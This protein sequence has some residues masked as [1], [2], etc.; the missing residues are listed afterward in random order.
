MNILPKDTYLGK[1]RF[2]EIYDEFYGPKCFSVKD[3][4]GHLYLVYWSGDYDDGK[5]TK[6]VYAPVSPAILDALLREEIS[7]HSVFSASKRLKIISTYDETVGKTTL[8]EDFNEGNSTSVNIPPVD[9]SID[10]EELKSIAPEANWDFNLRIAK[11][12]GN[13]LPSDDAVSKVLTA[14][15]DI[16]KLLMKGDKNWAPSVFPLTAQYGSFDVKLGS[17]NQERAA[18]A[19]E[20]L[21]TIL[22]KQDDILDTLA[23]LE[24][25]PYRM[26]DL[27]DIVNLESLELTLKS[28]TSETLKKPIKI[29]SSGLL[30]IIQKLE[31]DSKTFIDSSR[32]PQANCLDRVIKIVEHR[33][34]GGELNHKLIDGI[35]SE[36]QVIYHTH[37][38]KCLGLLNSNNTVTTAGRVLAQKDNDIA[39][40][41]YLADRME[42]SDFCWAWMRWANVSSMAE[43]EPST[44]EKFLSERVRGL[45]RTSI[46]R[47]ASSLSSWVT[48]LKQ[49]HRAYNVSTEQGK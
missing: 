46:A 13:G 40:Y 24:V 20:L 12:K 14:F 44:A 27:L 19:I 8:V 25:D 26:K 4:L 9:F 1:L 29:S 10:L 32:V 7:F 48:L 3:E 30:P 15:G 39:K 34:N 38:A 16:V 17:S 31:E 49:Y 2:F 28:K 41:Q 36:R 37:A 45:K 21:E 23:E 43:L 6:W 35:S 42:S 5:C 22:S 11:R 18:V 33:V 47:R